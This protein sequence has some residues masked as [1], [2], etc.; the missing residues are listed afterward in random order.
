MERPI[1]LR[2]WYTSARRVKRAASVKVMPA[3]LTAISATPRWARCRALPSV[4]RLRPE[5][6]GPDVD[7]DAAADVERAGFV[8]EGGRSMAFIAGP[9]CRERA[10]ARSDELA[11]RCA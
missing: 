3:M 6:V 11:P 1:R 7:G 2:S 9:P 10:G 5:A 8:D 4:R